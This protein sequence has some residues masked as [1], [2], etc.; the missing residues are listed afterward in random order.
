[1]SVTLYDHQK[2]DLDMLRK[3]K[4]YALWHD[5]GAG[6]THPLIFR[7]MDDV[8]AQRKGMWVI[9]AEVYL[10]LQWKRALDAMLS[11]L[12][13]KSEIITGDT[14]NW[15]RNKIMS[16]IPDILITN[17]EFFPKIKEWMKTNAVMGLVRGVVCDEAHKLKGF[18]GLRSKAG[19]RAKAIIE[20]AHAHPDIIRYAASGSPVVNPNNPEVWG[21]YYYL[22]PSIF[23]P[24]LWKFEQEFYYNISDNPKYEQFVLRDSMKAEMSRRMYLIARRV[25]KSELPIAFPDEVHTTYPVTM[26]AKLRKFY[27]ELQ[28]EAIATTEGKTV[29][30]PMI[31][32]RIMALQQV[33]SGFVL[34]KN[35]PEVFDFLNFD[36]EDGG[37]Q[38]E[39]IHVDSSHKD[40]AMWGIV[41]EVG[42]DKC[43]IIWGHFRHELRHIRKM[44]ESEGMKVACMWGDIPSAQKKQD[45]EDFIAGKKTHLVAQPASAGAGLNLQMA[46]HSI[47]YSR[48]HRLLDY[49]QSNGRNHRAGEQFHKSVTRHE[50]VTVNT[51]DEE[52]HEGLIHK[53]DVSSEI[54]L[55]HAKEQRS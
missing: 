30:R 47:R 11:D 20:V 25:L 13:V 22:D 54:T 49:I 4:T 35:R 36:S 27:D 37:L 1:M 19:T 14:E 32:S 51:K 46:G 38:E 52:I 50:L 31:L 21:L 23:G 33:A 12:G 8:I 2:V 16:D 7:I 3:F 6:K 18:K 55:D 45:L 24:T 9:V 41:D 48:S 5:V 28:R 42:R 53:R 44:L 29:V 17:Y 15:R 26:S 39:V 34:E 10:L 40:N 43:T